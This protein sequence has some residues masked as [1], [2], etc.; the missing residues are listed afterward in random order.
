MIQNTQHTG[1]PANGRGAD[2]SPSPNGTSAG[3]RGASD[4]ERAAND[5]RSSSVGE[6][7]PDKI[8]SKPIEDVQSRGD[9]RGIRLDRAGVAGVRYPATAIDPDGVERPTIAN[10]EMSVT[11]PAESKGT[12]MSRFLEIVQADG[13]VLDPD[14]MVRILRSMQG[15]LEAEEARLEID[16]TLF[17]EREAPVSKAKGLVDFDC[18]FIGEVNGDAVDLV[19]KVVVTVTSCCP[20]SKAISDYGAHNQRG[21]VTVEVRTRHDENG[22]PITIPT[23][24][25]IFAAEE[26]ASCRVYPVLKRPDERWVTMEAYENPVF[27]EDMVRGVADR[28]RQ[29]DRI[30]SFDVHARN[31]ESIHGHDAFASTSWSRE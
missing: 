6:A 13:R 25:L 21:E 2:V 22:M 15:R 27:V 23:G 11:V 10:L 18:G 14:G 16:F 28:L 24:D 17:M 29:D 12:H 9:T 31:F 7:R 3:G 5:P 19:Q 30:V 26:S 20:C 8:T 4:A 1:T